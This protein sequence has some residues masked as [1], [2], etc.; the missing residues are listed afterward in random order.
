[1]KAEILRDQVLME[2]VLDIFHCLRKAQKVP[3]SK[4]EKGLLKRDLKRFE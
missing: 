3:F 2:K 1:M 4:R